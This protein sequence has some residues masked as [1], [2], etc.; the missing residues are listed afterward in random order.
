MSVDLLQAPLAIDTL[1]GVQRAAIVVMQLEPNVASEIMRRLG[2][3]DAE[4]IATE[5][6]RLRHVD[7]T[8]A[9][10]VLADFHT[11]GTTGVQP[12]RGGSD[13]A[14]QLMSMSFGAKKSIGFRERLGRLT[15]G[16]SFEFLLKADPASI[17]ALLEGELPEVT[18]LVLGQLP[19]EVSSKVMARFDLAYRTD[20]AQ[21]IVTM[22]A[23]VAENLAIIADALRRRSRSLIS[24]DP[25][26]S[27]GGVQ[28]LVDI[29]S[30]SDVAVERALLDELATRDASLAEEVRAQLITFLDLTRLS[31]ADAQ[32]VLRGLDLGV[33]ARA[34]KGASQ[35]LIDTVV[36]NMTDRN[37]ELLTEE[38]ET[39]PGLRM[40]QIEEA[41]SEIARIIRTM[42]AEEAISLQRAGEDEFVE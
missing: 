5:I 23:P 11:L 36:R 7:P 28:S 42:L 9:E 13:Y 27:S 22:G 20:V 40:S 8:I 30:R 41:R 19:P 35:T 1:S 25:D 15:R 31:D 21:C 3:E 6:V 16:T 37:R 38:R 14:A 2:E 4:R 18:A 12:T 39:L 33:L 29:V 10:S 17:S 26:E 34:M 32:K 24:N